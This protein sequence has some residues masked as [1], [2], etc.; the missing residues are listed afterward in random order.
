M[1]PTSNGLLYLD[2]SFIREAPKF[3]II[4]LFGCGNV[5]SEELNLKKKTIAMAKV[6]AE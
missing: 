4:T 5:F 6:K 3:S 1:S 2:V